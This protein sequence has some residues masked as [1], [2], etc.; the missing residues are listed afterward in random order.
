MA[1][2]WKTRIDPEDYKPRVA[3]TLRASHA[4]IEKALSWG[5]SHEDL[6]FKELSSD[7]KLDQVNVD[8]AEKALLAMHSRLDAHHTLTY[9]QARYLLIALSRYRAGKT[10]EQAF[11]LKKKQKPGRNIVSETRSIDRAME[12][13][14]A[15][16]TGKSVEEAVEI[17]AEQLRMKR[18]QVAKYWAAHKDQAMFGIQLERKLTAD[19][20]HHY[21]AW[22][23]KTKRRPKSSR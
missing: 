17:A 11:G 18:T 6:W 12:V 20:Q 8:Y 16:L 14:R 7:L 22:E 19:E 1:N 10:L 3:F 5:L 4:E 9:H 15:I 21:D 23:K 13:A 2:K